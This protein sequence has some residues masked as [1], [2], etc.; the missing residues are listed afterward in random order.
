MTA[1]ELTLLEDH[2]LVLGYG[3]L[4]EP[5]LEELDDGTDVVVVTPDTETASELRDRDDLN[6]LTADPTDE[7]ALEDASVESASGVVAVTDDDA[8]NTLAVLAASRSNPD[9]RI[10][11]AARE[12]RHADK[13][14]DVG[15]DEVVTP[16][17]IG[18]RI[19]GRSVLGESTPQFDDDADAND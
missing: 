4:A 2:V 10:V 14:T 1:S 3:D 9:V 13:L 16:A 19:L 11:A 18:G 7:T 6:V 8:Q 12:P 17:V 5:L 15:A